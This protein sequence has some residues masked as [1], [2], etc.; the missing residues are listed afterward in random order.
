MKQQVN[1][2]STAIHN[3]NNSAIILH[4]NEKRFKEN[5]I[6]LNEFGKT[7]S[8]RQETTEYGSMISDHVNLLSELVTELSEE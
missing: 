7:I 6:K 4:S 8:Q 5:F 3:L 1:I 2:L